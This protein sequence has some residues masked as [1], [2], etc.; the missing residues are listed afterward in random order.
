MQLDLLLVRDAPA[1]HGLLLLSLL[2]VGALGILGV[3]PLLVLAE[4]EGLLHLGVVA[5][6][7]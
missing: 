3:Q 6:P 5:E 1:Q 7:A 4:R 2:R